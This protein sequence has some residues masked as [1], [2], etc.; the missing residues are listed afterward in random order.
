MGGAS[1]RQQ[2]GD[3]RSHVVE[4]VLGLLGECTTSLTPPPQCDLIKP[5]TAGGGGV[6]WGGAIG[7]S[8]PCCCTL[9]SPPE[10]ANTE[11]RIY[12]YITFPSLYKIYRIIISPST[13]V[14]LFSNSDGAAS[15][16]I[17]WTHG[18]GAGP[19][20]RRDSHSA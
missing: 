5:Q 13:N 7:G 4:A 3:W 8:V 6:G 18:R 9:I 12:I 19:G 2:Y 10:G 14:S 1:C 15:A 11:N 17:F 20:R 16:S